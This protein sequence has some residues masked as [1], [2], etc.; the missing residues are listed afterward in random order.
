M[1][2]TTHQ[3]SPELKSIVDRGY[4]FAQARIDIRAATEAHLEVASGVRLCLA[5]ESHNAPPRA[6]TVTREPWGPEYK[7][8]GLDVRGTNAL[9][10]DDM[11]LVIT[12]VRG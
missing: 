11:R 4:L 2:E 6:V 3:M 12:E 7:L 10:G 5:M 9:A 8:W 1:T